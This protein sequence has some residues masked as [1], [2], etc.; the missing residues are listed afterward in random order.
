MPL[1]KQI[2]VFTAV[3]FKGNPVA[4]FFDADHLSTAEMAQMSTWTNLSEAT[5]VLK[6]T[7]PGAD[8]RVRIFSRDEELPFAGHPTIGTCFALLEAGLIESHEGKIV[9]ECKGG[10]VQLEVS[11]DRKIQFQLPYARRTEPSKEQMDKLLDV[12]GKSEYIGAA[13]YEVGPFWFAVELPNAAD[14]LSVASSSKR[15]TDYCRENKISGFQLLG[16]QADRS[17]V[18][19]TLDAVVEEDPV[20]GSGS[21]ATGAYLR[22]THGFTGQFLINQGHKLARDGKVQVTVDSDGAIKVAGN[23]VTVIDGTY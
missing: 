13:I 6:P 14:V 16:K 12:I 5:F 22:D 10:L 2:D 9:Q 15:V 1:F 23:A 3:K 11:S 18:T 4:V 19:R 20:C 17:Y 7:Q 8:Y 21:G